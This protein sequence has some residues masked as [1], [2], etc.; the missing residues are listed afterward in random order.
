MPHWAAQRD[1]TGNLIKGSVIFSSLI[2]EIYKYNAVYPHY[3]YPNFIKT[4]LTEYMYE[5]TLT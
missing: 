4:A 5:I 3:F 2:Q 1:T